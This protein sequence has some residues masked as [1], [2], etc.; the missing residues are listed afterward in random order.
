MSSDDAAL[1]ALA[2]ALAPRILEKVRELL[3]AEAGDDHALG[4]AVMARLGYQPGP[5][6]CPVNRS[7]SSDEPRKRRKPKR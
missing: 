4:L 6:P 3:A 1:D 5:K 2:A 7:L